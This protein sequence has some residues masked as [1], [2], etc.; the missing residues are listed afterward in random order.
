VIS[1]NNQ[2]VLL[3]ADVD[4]EIMTLILNFGSGDADNMDVSSVIQVSLPNPNS[5][6]E[7]NE[8]IHVKK[9]LLAFSADGSKFATATADGRVSI[10]DVR[11]KAPLKVFLVDVS[12]RYSSSWFQ[13]V[14]LLQFSGGILGK[15][16]LVFM[17]VSLMRSHILNPHI[18][19][20]Q[21]NCEIIHIID[22]TSFETEEILCLPIIWPRESKFPKRMSTLCFDPNGERM[23]TEQGGTLYEWTLRKNEGPEW[24]LGEE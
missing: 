8:D 12:R 4:N 9:V 10:W 11:S 18:H 7:R 20:P 15:E 24:W 21:S 17:E 1:Y 23:Y 19:G 6:T 16:V 13:P 22:A 3:D 14:L 5:I 2:P